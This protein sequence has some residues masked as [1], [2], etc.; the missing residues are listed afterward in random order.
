MEE[1]FARA[2]QFI[3]AGFAAFGVALWF[4]LAVWTYR[5]IE[6]RSSNVAV[7]VLATLVVVLGFIPGAVIY[8]L[9]RPRETASDRYQREVEES[10]LAQELAATEG[11]PRCGRFVDDEFI[12]CPDCGSTLR[13]TCPSCGRFAGS[14][15][16]VCA[17][18]RHD[19]RHRRSAVPNGRRSESPASAASRR[20][21]NTDDWEI[22]LEADQESGS[23]TSNPAPNH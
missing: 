12:F 2:L 19:L 23:S 21:P 22:D 13:R 14:D 15:W 7:Q 9:L 18:C 6:Q 3:V 4:A 17:Y 20:Y 10:Y 8:L 16:S 11:C 1:T 5:D